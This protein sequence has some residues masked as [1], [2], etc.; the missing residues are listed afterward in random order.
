MAVTLDPETGH[1][2]AIGYSGGGS[3]ALPS[4][5]E[6]ATS[7]FKDGRKILLTM[8]AV[9]GLAFLIALLTS[10]R[11]TAT[12]SLLVLLGPEYGYRGPAGE[13]G[14][15][16]AYFDR[17]SILQTEINILKSRPMLEQ[18]IRTV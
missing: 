18:V 14:S 5:R 12:S 10:S 8:A 15:I 3:S 16:N 9:F 1:P 2:L 17:E 11:Y 6:L 13:N 4:S 7:L